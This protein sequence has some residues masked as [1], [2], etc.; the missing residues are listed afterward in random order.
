VKL[1]PDDISFLEHAAIDYRTFEE[2]GVLNVELL[3]F[4]F[5]PGLT[6]ERGSV[7][8]RLAPSYPDTPPDMWWV[9]PHLTASGQ[10]I[11]ATELT[12]MYDG[13]TWQRWSRHLDPGIWKS[14][15]DGLESYIRVLRTELT[16]AAALAEAA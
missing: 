7:L 12:E 4:P 2:V 16:T 5:P 9:I 8:F 13:R 10:T 1:P 3:D 15:I 6:T 11:P 14:G